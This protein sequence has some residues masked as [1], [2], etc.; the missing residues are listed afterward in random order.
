[1][2]QGY[3][4]SVMF[5]AVCEAAGRF[6]D[7]RFYLYSMFLL[8]TELDEALKDTAFAFAD[9][10]IRENIKSKHLGSL[11][12]ELWAAFADEELTVP[13]YEPERVS[14]VRQIMKE[15][16]EAALKNS[17]RSSMPDQVKK[18]AA[19]DEDKKALIK[20]LAGISGSK[21]GIKGIFRHK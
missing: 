1:M 2:P 3:T 18:A 4:K 10:L 19:P 14:Q 16:F 13:A 20:M 6:N 12:L 9:T 5:G 11:L 17:Y 8:D 21:G 7:R 15:A